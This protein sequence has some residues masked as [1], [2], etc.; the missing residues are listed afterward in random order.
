MSNVEAARAGYKAFAAGDLEGM[1]RIWAD[2]IHWWNSEE[3][4]PGGE[5]NGIDAVMQMIGSIPQYWKS[6]TVNPAKFIDAGDYVI[7]L[8]TQTLA[9]DKG[10]AEGR[11]AHIMKFQDGKCVDAEMHADTAKGLKL[12]G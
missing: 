10:S 2:D 8:G 5:Y 12:Q 6:M 11:F 1:K 9:N 3:V 4:Q 7:A